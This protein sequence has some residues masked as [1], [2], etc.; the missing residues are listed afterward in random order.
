MA[1]IEFDVDLFEKELKSRAS[2]VPLLPYLGQT[3]S[4]NY[5]MGWF[6]VIREETKEKKKYKTY[7][8]MMDDISFL[9]VSVRSILETNE[10]EIKNV[11]SYLGG[12]NV[13]LTR[14][15]NNQAIKR[16]KNFPKKEYSYLRE[17]RIRKGKSNELNYSLERL[18]STY[19][20]MIVYVY[21]YLICLALPFCIGFHEFWDVS[22]I[23]I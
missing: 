2:F 17:K 11:F 12:F 22:F 1:I 16:M 15:Q 7:Y 13:N 23:I 8:E 5:K 4:L 9:G 6:V 18:Y 20:R 10:F 19:S 3:I 14:G 21:S